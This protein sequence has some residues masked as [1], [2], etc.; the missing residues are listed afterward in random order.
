MYK[1]DY[2]LSK[3]KIP[4]TITLILL[5]LLLFPCI[6]TAAINVDGKLDEPEWGTAQSLRDFEV[7][8]PMTLETPSLETEARVLATEEGLAIAVICEQPSTIKRT[9]TVTSRDA[10]EFDCDSITV[11]VDFDGT[12]KIAYEFGVSLTGS[13]SDGIVTDS[14]MFSNDDWDPVWQRAVYEE[15]EQWTVEML[16]PWSI[17]AMRNGD[18]KI[19][20][21]GVF[22]AREVQETK[23]VFGLPG[24]SRRQSNFMNDFAKVEIPNYTFTSQQLDVVPYVTVISDTVNH[25]TKGR[26]GVDI[27]WKPSSIFQVVATF[28]PDFGQVESD[29]LVIN[30]TAFETFF[31]DKRPFFT[32]NQGIFNVSMA[33]AGGGRGSGGGPGSGSGPGSG[34]SLIYTRRIGGPRDDNR[35]ASNIQGAL[36]V[37]GSAGPINYGVFTAKEDEDAG[38]TFYAGRVVLP[39]DKW[40]LGWL[41]TYV[42]RP[43]LDRTGLVNAFDYD[44]RFGESLRWNGQLIRSEIKTLPGRSSGTAFWGALEYTV[45]KDQHYAISFDRYDNKFDID[46][47]G[48]LR[49][50]DTEDLSVRASWQFNDFS[51]DSHISSVSWHLMGD[52]SRNTA[53]DAFPAN[54]MLN[55]GTD[56]R[57]GDEIMFNLNFSSSGYDDRISRGNGL[58]RLNKRFGVNFHY[59]TSRQGDWKKSFGI[60]ISQEG[61]E[62]WGLGFDADTV[63]YPSDN[64][65]L[66]LSLS[67]SWSRDWL[68]WIRGTQLGSFSRRQFT[69][70]LSA[71]WFPAAKHEL[72]L[73]TQWAAVDAEAEQSYFIGNGGHLIADNQPMNDFAQINFGL[74]FRYRYEIGPLSD[75]YFVY[76]RG[77]FDYINNPDKNTIHLL[78]DTIK[79]RDS[80]QILVKVRYCF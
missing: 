14:I 19:R 69:A 53:G 28:N 60:S 25:T 51:E 17:A 64:F 38:R 49:R 71:N 59:S 44:F 23:E 54:V 50:N 22:F 67:P 40:S 8:N 18:G 27:S 1:C 78:R 6:G 34:N 75:F 52:L 29:D 45:S 26:A 80:D 4:Y 47:M 36:K 16:L 66:D 5:N 65:N 35:E 21:I 24:V 10:R 62:G 55:M 46:D 57:G 3:S 13:Y 76:S 79:L 41:T 48:Y 37:I 74:Q 70:R 12:G 31:S 72:R 32:E 63:W 2:P 9:H 20:R 43:F 30:F 11:M 33:S 56:F 73:R 7:I 68:I 61:Y 39:K 77:G 15:P 58:V 42:E